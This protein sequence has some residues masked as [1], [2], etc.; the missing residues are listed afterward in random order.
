VFG[1]QKQELLYYQEQEKDYRPVGA[2]K[3]LS[4]LPAPYRTQG[5]EVGAFHSFSR[6]QV[7]GGAGGI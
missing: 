4:Q 5:S 1:L 7:L 3:V 2:E 6:S